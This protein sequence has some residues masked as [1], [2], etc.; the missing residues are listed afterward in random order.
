MSLFKIYTYTS[1]QIIIENKHIITVNNELTNHYFNSDSI[2]NKEKFKQ[3]IFN[4]KYNKIFQIIGK[5]IIILE[6]NNIVLEINFPV[7]YVPNKDNITYS[8]PCLR[9]Y[10][11]NKTIQE[12][13]YGF[14]AQNIIKDSLLLKLKL[15]DKISF[16]I[17]T[18]IKENSF[19]HILI[20]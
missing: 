20:A 4:D 12:K 2:N 10:L 8:L 5:D 3:I 7:Y 19:I 14:D 17:D 6:D 9:I 15:G 1:D 18:P 16:G 11:N 13:R